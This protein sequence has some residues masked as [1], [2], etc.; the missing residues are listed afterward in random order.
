MSRVLLLLACQWL[1]FGPHRQEPESK[2]G[3]TLAEELAE[4]IERT[5]AL[6]SFHCVWR[7]EL[8]GHAL[9]LAYEAPHKGR[10]KTVTPEGVT[11]HCFDEKGLYFRTDE[12]AWRYCEI[13]RSEGR[14][15]LDE[16]FPIELPLGPGFEL[17]FDSMPSFH[18]GGREALLWW[19]RWMK[20]ECASVSR[21]G[22]ELVL[23]WDFGEVRVARD[24]GF[25]RQFTLQVEEE[26][27]TFEM[28][29][30]SL[31]EEVLTTLPED[32][33]PS[34]RDD[35]ERAMIEMQFYPSFVRSEAFER[36][37]AR[38]AAKTLEWNGRTRADWDEFLVV[39][40]DPEIQTAHLEW[41]KELLEYIKDSIA[42]AR[43]TLEQSDTPEVRAALASYFDELEQ[44]LERGF[45]QASEVYLA[46]LSELEYARPELLE[47]E[48][49]TILRLHDEL[50]S[51]PI[52]EFLGEA[53]ETLLGK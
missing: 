34:T 15:T 25:P 37:G 39:Q 45:E 5:N 17:R 36:V 46:G 21:E 28:V 4:L 53:R 14:E 35:M 50:I 20:R 19:L 47:A 29:Q 49:E 6:D 23:T 32:F 43:A 9:E 38:L 12:Q 51:Q 48:R 41:F 11:E 1:A 42:R 22:D 24:S 27:I 3:P 18:A 31:D 40:H 10:M 52:L 26:P 44:E 30:C 13:P 16:L 2:E 8:E 7:G 33:E